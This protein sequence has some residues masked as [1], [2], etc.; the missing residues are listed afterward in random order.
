M[1]PPRRPAQGAKLVAKGAGHEE[2]HHDAGDV[3]FQVEYAPHP[4]FTVAENGIDL[5]YTE[6]IKLVDALL[7]FS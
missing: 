1:C 3:V 6:R 7:G 2:L 4:Q 5:V